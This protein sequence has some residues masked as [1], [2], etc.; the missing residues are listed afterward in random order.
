[1]KVAMAILRGDKDL[2]CI[3]GTGMGKTLTFWMPLLFRP[4]GIQIVV[5]PLNLLG[6]QNVAALE[7]AHI[8]AVSIN[9]ET[10]TPAI[11]HVRTPVTSDER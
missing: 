1:M 4:D 11:F 9:S 8:P 6:K 7:R 10:A 5:T 3:A 2:L